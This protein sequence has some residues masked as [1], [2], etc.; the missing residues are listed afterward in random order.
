MIWTN[1][2]EKDREGI[3]SETVNGGVKSERVSGIDTFTLSNQLRS[4]WQLESR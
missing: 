4:N 3:R 1:G 2:K